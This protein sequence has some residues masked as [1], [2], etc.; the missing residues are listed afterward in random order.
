M[1]TLGNAVVKHYKKKYTKNNR[2]STEDNY[3]LGQ[4]REYID[5]VFMLYKARKTEAHLRHVAKLQYGGNIDEVMCKTHFSNVSKVKK[6]SEIFKVRNAFIFMFEGAPGI[7]KTTVAQQIAYEWA[8]GKILDHIELLLLLYFKDPELQ[9]VKKFDD[10]MQYCNAPN[11]VKYFS[12]KL[13]ENLLLVFDGY[14]ELATNTKMHSFFRMLLVREI[15]PS[16]SIVFTSRPYSTV[17]LHNYCDYNIEILGFSESD[18]FDFLIK[19]NI[20]HDETNM[21]KRF[22]QENLI[23]NSL[24]YIPF[25]MASLLILIHEKKDLPKTQTELTKES[26]SST[27]S[28]HI[29]RS[30]RNVNITKK[31]IMDTLAHLAFEMIEKNKFVFTEAEIINAGFRLLRINK[32]AFGLIQA[33]QFTDVRNS[34]DTI[35]YSFVH[36]SVQEYLAAYYLS[37]RF[38]VAQS[39]HLHHKF[40]DKR[41][42]GIWTMYTGITQ[43]KKFALQQFLSGENYITGGFRYLTGQEFPGVCEEIKVKKVKCLLLYQMLLEAPDSKIE[44]SLNNVVKNDTI[45]LNNEKF[46]SQ[47]VNILTYCITRSYITMNWKM[48]NLS[49]C[50]IGDKEC[51]EIF[52]GLSCDDGHKKPTIYYLNLSNN[53]ITFEKFFKLNNVHETSTKI[54]CLNI[55]DNNVTNFKVL[56]HLVKVHKIT[57]LKFCNNAQQIKHLEVLENNDTISNLNLCYNHWPTSEWILPHL[58]NLHTLNLSYPHLEVN[59]SLTLHVH[60]NIFC[61]LKELILSHCLL[62]ADSISNLFYAIPKT[63]QLLDLSYNQIDDQAL[64]SLLKFFEC[65]HSLQNL[66]LVATGLDGPKSLRCVQAL[67]DSKQLEILDMSENYITDDK[68]VLVIELCKK[69]ST[70]KELTIQNFYLTTTMLR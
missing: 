35:L 37:Q 39:F 34:A 48:I 20:S 58:P 64:A 26:I 9:K 50:E 22:L 61:S 54:N 70:I 53:N 38:F 18:R 14:D 4:T 27:V 6:L 30:S 66:S 45:N 42:L 23:I 49:N 3:A 1:S 51:S 31:H 67:T 17:N 12:E 25:N 63:V 7:G 33:V 5:L 65:N 43:G 10:L 52:Q 69:I 56:N 46:C 13:G 36:F 40:W 62:T 2:F 68:A 21:I 19:H 24:C 44:E 29:R 57:E 41:Y 15:L 32:K 11:C 59:S 16:C 8:E 55:S 60:H 47:D 28:H